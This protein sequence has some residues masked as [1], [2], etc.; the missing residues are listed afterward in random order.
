MIVRMIMIVMINFFFVSLYN[1]ELIKSKTDH[2]VNN[3]TVQLIVFDL[4]NNSQR[5]DSLSVH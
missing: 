5:I 4:E 1:I 2:A 3:N